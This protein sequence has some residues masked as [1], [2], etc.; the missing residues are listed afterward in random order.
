[1]KSIGTLVL[2]VCQFAVCSAADWPQWMGPER[3]NVWRETGIVDEL[4]AGGP[5]IAWRSPVAGG[6]AGPAV[7]DGKGVCYRLRGRRIT[8]NV[9]NFERKE[10]T[11]TER[12]HCL[13]EA[14]G[15]EL[16]KHE[17]PVKYT[18]SY[19]GRAALYAGRRRRQGVHARRRGQS[20]RLR[21]Q[22]GRGPLVA[23]LQQ[24]VRRED[25]PLG[26]RRPSARGRQQAD[27]HRRRRGKLRRRLRQGH[28]QGAV[29]ESHVAGAR[30]LTAVDSRNR[31]PAATRAPAARRA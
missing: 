5:K 19:P 29:E 30:L 21:R 10:F 14:T 15:K 24:G 16:W 20:F 25:G 18:I 26:L 4:P 9:A 1:M 28:R 23:R 13:D 11:G 3:D 2:V 12:V 17:Y 22:D 6:Y 31:R 8:V 7:A 27:L